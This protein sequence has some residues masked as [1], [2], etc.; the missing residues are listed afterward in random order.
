VKWIEAFG[1]DS[2]EPTRELTAS[3]SSTGLSGFISGAGSG[4]KGRVV[5]EFYQGQ[6]DALQSDAI[7]LKQI[8]RQGFGAKLKETYRAVSTDSLTISKDDVAAN[9]AVLQCAA[10]GGD[11]C[12]HATSAPGPLGGEP[13]TEEELAAVNAAMETAD[14]SDCREL[15]RELQKHSGGVVLVLLPGSGALLNTLPGVTNVPWFLHAAQETNQ[16]RVI[17]PK[18]RQA[19]SSRQDWQHAIVGSNPVLVQEE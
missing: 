19:F 8:E 12:T 15:S 2:R 13:L 16:G 1:S 18:L 14:E 4:N 5:H 11:D 3:R 9:L 6:L 10:R 7:A 17:D